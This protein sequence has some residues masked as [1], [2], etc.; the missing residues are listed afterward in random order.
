MGCSKVSNPPSGKVFPYTVRCDNPTNARYVRI[1]VQPGKK[2]YLH[3]VQVM[4][5]NLHNTALKRPASQSSDY[6]EGHSA[7]KAVD[8]DGSTFSDTLDAAVN[9]WTVDLGQLT[10]V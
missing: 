1:S 7:D 10:H 6:S 5:V 2:L 4:V 3:E 8:G 9:W